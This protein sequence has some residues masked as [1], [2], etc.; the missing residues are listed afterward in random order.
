MKLSSARAFSVSIIMLYAC[1]TA[2]DA[3]AVNPNQGL[4][5]IK[6]TT[7]TTL[8]GSGLSNV[9]SR[10]TDKLLTNCPNMA[11][12]IEDCLSQGLGY[13]NATDQNGCPVIYCV[14]DAATTLRLVKPV[15]VTVTTQ[16]AQCPDTDAAIKACAA[17]GM[18]YAKYV[19]GACTL[20]QC[21]TTTTVQGNGCPD[22]QRQMEE[23]KGKG[24]TISRRY[25]ENKCVVIDC[26][27]P[28]SDCPPASDVEKAIGT[29]KE[30]GLGYVT[31][32]KDGCRYAEC[33]K[34][35][36]CPAESDLEYA[37][38]KCKAAG[39]GYQTYADQNGCRQVKCV[40]QNP[41]PTDEQN[42]QR[43]EECRKGGKGYK[44]V[45]TGQAATYA[46]AYVPCYRVECVDDN[47]VCPSVKDDM[48]G[49]RKQG[50]QYEYYVDGNGCERARC[51]PKPGDCRPNCPTDEE[52][53]NMILKCEANGMGYEFYTGT[54]TYAA[55]A[56]QSSEACRRVRCVEKACPPNAELER[57]IKACAAKKLTAQTYVDDAGCKRVECVRSGD[58]PDYNATDAIVRACREKKLAVEAYVDEAGCKNVRCR[59]PDAEAT[60]DC[61]KFL[62]GDCVI[63]SCSDGY[64]FDSCNPQGQCPQV[65]CKRFKDE[66]GCIVKRC[67]D[68]S[69]SRE[70]PD[71][72]P[73]ECDVVKRDDGCLVKKCSDGAEYV[74]CPTSQN[75]KDYVDENKCKVH[76]CADGTKERSCPDG[77]GDVE[78]KVYADD[79]G[80]LIKECTNGF[81]ESS[82]DA[83]GGC[84]DTKDGDC[85]VTTCPTGATRKCPGKETVECKTYLSDDGCKVT[86]CTDGREDKVCP[87]TAAGKPSDAGQATGLT[88]TTTLT[89]TGG[90]GWLS[91]FF[92]S[93]GL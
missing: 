39:M 64:T 66:K 23:C 42:R 54:P 13:T 37:A 87:M 53:K 68:G 9:I 91:S 59:E 11:G 25:D 65:E 58:C 43:M 77:S 79:A 16:P 83:T 7:T 29:C 70:C 8:K 6:L 55:A 63:V 56:A 82:C 49:C 34:Q 5:D 81:K 88:T 17:K 20:I 27:V 30:K 86:V 1:M 46:V 15:Q 22:V 36:P 60:V 93:L 12:K 38:R 80:C 32:E 26:A 74:S 90:G 33:V 45:P 75:C 85:T 92:R 61:R 51:A 78:C 76:E 71:Q 73:V 31:Y 50:L 72:N 14:F 41:C 89:K 47:P 2:A 3:M 19:T 40:Q 62:K 52:L 57:L 69:E 21:T 28:A 35:T 10:Q 44:M 24:G 84:K 48:E 4:S 18:G 67:T